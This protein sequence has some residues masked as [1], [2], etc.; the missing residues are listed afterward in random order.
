M[1]ETTKEFGFT[2]IKYVAQN[3]R[4]GKKANIC[5]SNQRVFK[6]TS[7]NN[8]ADLLKVLFDQKIFDS[9]EVPD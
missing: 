9:F 5:F 4:Q 8:K 1:E 6:M 3:D 2:L 7:T